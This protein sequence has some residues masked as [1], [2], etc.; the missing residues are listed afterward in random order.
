MF[1]F[2]QSKYSEKYFV[3]WVLGG[4]RVSN[5]KKGDTIPVVFG[6]SLVL[7][8]GGGAFHRDVS[9]LVYKGIFG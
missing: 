5:S 4:I 2:T 3:G 6:P 8:S 9:Y 1:G 7:I